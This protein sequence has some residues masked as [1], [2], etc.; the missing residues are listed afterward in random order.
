MSDIQF[1]EVDAEKIN[2]EIIS[3]FEAVL[4]DTLYPGDERRIFL[5]QE[6]Q[7]IVGLKNDINETAKQNLLRYAGGE[8]LD[9]IGERTDTVRIQAQKAKTTIRFTLSAAQTADIIVP[10]GTRVTPDGKLYFATTSILVI[11]S[12]QLYG[13]IEAESI[14]G[15]E[16]YNN[17]TPGQIKTIV[18]PIPFVASAANTD[19]SSNGSDIE[20]DDSYRERIR[21][22]PSMFSTAGPSD[23]YIYWAKTADVDIEDVS[24]TSPNPGQVKITVLM[25]NG[26]LPAQ[27]ILDAVSASCSDK[28]RRPLTDQVIAAAPSVVNYDINL[29]YY[30]SKSV[31]AEEVNIKNSVEGSGGAIDQYNEWQSSKLGREINPDYLRQLLLN[32]GAYKIDLTAPAYTTLNDDQVAKVQTITVNYGGLI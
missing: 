30:I 16:K 8:L 10:Q 6:A 7:T 13:D 5:N 11:P 3:D 26:E 9:A 17:F 19:T 27:V 21:E 31:T 24:V 22:A 28:K 25:K 29:T 1:V 32:A 4:G 12:G 23:A 18:D 15:G 20:S 14:E 2:N